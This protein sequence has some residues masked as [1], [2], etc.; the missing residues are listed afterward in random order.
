M[1]LFKFVVEDEHGKRKV[2][3][4]FSKHLN[5]AVKKLYQEYNF[6]RIVALAC[7]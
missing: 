2:L 7:Q 6:E 4:V 1:Q 5:G 3:S